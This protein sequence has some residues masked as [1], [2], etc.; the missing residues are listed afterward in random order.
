MPWTPEQQAE[1]VRAIAIFGGAVILAWVVP[2]LIAMLMRR[3]R[4]DA[5]IGSTVMRAIRGPLGGLLIVQALFI[6]LHTLSYLQ[7]ESHAI[8]RVWFSFTVAVFAYAIQR[9]AARLLQWYAERSV[10]GDTR[11]DARSL[12]ILRRALNVAIWLVSGLLI[13][14]A[15]GVQISPLLA[16]LGLGGLAVA[17]ALQPMLAN[18]FAS[19]YLLSDQSIRVGDAILVQGGPSG[20]IEDIGWRATR[21]R[22]L[23]HDLV[24]IPNSVLAQSTMTNFDA[25]APETDV[26]LTLSVPIAADLELVERACLDELARLCEEARDVVVASVPPSFHYEGID[27]AR[28]R[29]LV[30]VRVD[31]WRAVADLR[32]RMILRLH[33]RMRAEGVSLA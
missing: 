19:S 10:R 11:I 33:S 17:L 6:A 2:T 32:H 14:D 15:L 23:D 29:I 8:D 28:V 26:T 30:R 16:G 1:T 27:A 3:G 9:V 13:L 31:S 7:S 4:G 18:V 24:I 20:T 12:P 21:I 22:T 25:A 5:E